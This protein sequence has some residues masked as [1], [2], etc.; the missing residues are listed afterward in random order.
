MEI[1]GEKANVCSSPN[2]A[3]PCATR[4]PKTPNLPG[5][6]VVV[7]NAPDGETEQRTLGAP[8]G[9]TVEH[10]GNGPMLLEI[11]PWR[12]N[13]PKSVMSDGYAGLIT[14]R[15]GQ[16]SSIAPRGE[17]LPLDCRRHNTVGVGRRRERKR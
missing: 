1:S 12:W 6:K 5:S 3:A 17:F 2:I 15:Q 16:F 8:G 14:L 9:F 13:P 10:G 4:I 7:T 11:S